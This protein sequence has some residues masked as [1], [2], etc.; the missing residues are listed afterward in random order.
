MII[1]F[2]WQD[3][4][5]EN[6]EGKLCFRRPFVFWID[7]KDKHGWYPLWIKKPRFYDPFAKFD[8]NG[9]IEGADMK[10]IEIF[11]LYGAV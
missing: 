11:R 10:E 1:Y 8:E 4:F 9:Y 6:H 7:K 3:F 5:F 2:A